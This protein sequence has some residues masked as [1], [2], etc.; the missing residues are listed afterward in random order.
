L[1]GLKIVPLKFDTNNPYEIA[2]S[3]Y[4]EI[5][6]VEPQA[7]FEAIV[8]IKLPKQPGFYRKDYN[9]YDSNGMII[10]NCPFYIIIR[11]IPDEICSPV[12][13]NINVGD[14][15]NG[16][17]TG[18]YIEKN[19]YYFCNWGV[20]YYTRTGNLKNQEIKPYVD[21]HKNNDRY[22][23]DVNCKD[24]FDEGKEVYAISDGKVLHI[25]TKYGAIWILH[26]YVSKDLEN[27]YFKSGYIAVYMHLDKSSWTN[28]S[29]S[30]Q[31]WLKDQTIRKGNLLG[32]IGKAG[33][34]FNHLHF[35]IYPLPFDKKISSFS[36]HDWLNYLTSVH[37]EIKPFP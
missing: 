27:E 33:A 36:D 25:D 31:F 23:W 6:T 32:F 10:N 4:E 2:T 12:K 18:K 15:I 19:I 30:K 28:N 14:L 35:A 21:T 11:V 7:E 16:M 13:G 9:L 34:D 22:A 24:D 1:E 17:D 29:I 5:H 26:D 8:K 20:F 3:N 37:C